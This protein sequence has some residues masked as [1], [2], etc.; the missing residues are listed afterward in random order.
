MG[1]KMSKPP[2]Q[3]PPELALGMARGGRKER[4]EAAVRRAEA[5]AA[6]ALAP[7]ERQRQRQIGAALNHLIALVMPDAPPTWR[8]ATRGKLIAALARQRLALDASIEQAK[9]RSESE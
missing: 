4:H 3:I 8:E 2:R 9:N 5:A 6:A 1:G 7:D